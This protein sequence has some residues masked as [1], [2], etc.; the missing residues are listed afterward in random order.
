MCAGHY[1]APLAGSSTLYINKRLASQP[2]NAGVL[3]EV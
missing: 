2:A 1:V 3:V